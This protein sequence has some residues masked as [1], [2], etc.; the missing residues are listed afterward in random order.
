MGSAV[1]YS[2]LIYGDYLMLVEVICTCTL[3]L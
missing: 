3:G 1:F 2:R